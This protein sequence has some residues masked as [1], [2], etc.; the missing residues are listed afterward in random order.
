MTY[1]YG[2]IIS[3]K[4]NAKPVMSL[5]AETF[6]S[7]PDDEDAK[8]KTYW[9]LPEEAF[10]IDDIG[11]VYLLPKYA[12]RFR[13]GVDA[14]SEITGQL[15]INVAYDPEGDVNPGAFCS[16]ISIDDVENED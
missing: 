7:F 14:Y 11:S 13:W 4:E 5:D 6:F 12:R 3:L 1:E 8:I 9:G 15:N 2:D 16:W 10:E